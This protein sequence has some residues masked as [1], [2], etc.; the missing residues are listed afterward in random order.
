VPVYNR[1]VEMVK[2][3]IAIDWDAA[4]KKDIIDGD[5]Y[6]ADL[7][8]EDNVTI[9][10][11]LFVLLKDNSYELDRHLDD[12]GL[13]ASRAVQFKDG[14][15]SH[16]HFWE[17]YVRPPK[18]EYQD[19]I[20]KRRDLLVP[21]DVRE[22]KGAFYTPAQWVAKAHEYLGKTFGGDW[23][24]EYTV[25]DNSA[26]SGNLLAGLVNKDNLWA[27]TLD[28]QDVSVM[29]DRIG[30]GANLWKEQVFQFDFLNDDFIPV[31]KGGKL[32]DKLFQIISDPVKRKKLIFLINPPYGEAG[33]GQGR[34][35]KAGVKESKTLDSFKKI[36]GGLALN[37]K[38]IQFFAR[39]YS[40][41]PNCKMAAF[42]TPKYICGVNMKKFR[43]FW[44]AEYLGGFATPATTHDNCSGKYPIC[45]FIWDLAMKDNFPEKIPCDVFNKNEKNEGVKYF[46]TYEGK[47][48][49]IDW[50]R[51]FIDRKNNELGSLRIRNN[52]F[53]SQDNIAI[54]SITANADVIKKRFTYIT[55][56]NVIPVVI[57]YAV[58][59]CIERT[60]INQNDNFLYP[61]DGWQT[62][63]EFQNDCLVFTL[64][65][66]KN[67]IKSR[68]GVNH[69]IPFTEAEVG[70]D[71]RFESR[72]MSDFISGKTPPPDS[73]T[74]ASHDGKK[75][76][77]SEPLKFSLEASAV[78][79]AG[80]ELWKYYHS[81]PNANA[82]ASFYEIRE[83]FQGRKANG[84]MNTKSTDA[85]Y[86]ELIGALRDRLKVL[87]KKIEPKVYEYEFLLE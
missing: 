31:S 16:R 30:N 44:K 36:L 7:I 47:Q 33:T 1:W 8:A 68:E 19:Y 23:Q 42:V 37:E 70:C 59:H 34:E 86:N 79:D 69:W 29:H 50:F 72:F 11:D 87:S 83:H 64:F 22:R 54:F 74:A 5:F 10:E 20:K 76:P 4:K 43:N 55:K 39:I 27:S 56:K 63:K 17:L 85:K 49:I 80:R 24:D 65:H 51:N 78:F 26:G 60:W 2:P 48:Y 13:F 45:L 58:R 18:E 9:N 61:N 15:L 28:K 32:P 12:L 35:H 53:Q 52:D 67:K 14:G 81:Q 25:W 41:I 73:N 21:Q 75:N 46:Y 82:N 3:S 38:F 66:G 6:L 77:K 40:D 84:N 71:T 62:D 57:Y